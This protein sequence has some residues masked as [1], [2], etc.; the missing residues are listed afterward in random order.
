MKVRIKFS[1]QGAMKFIGHL[2]IMRYFQK[3]IRRAGI[4]IAYTEG[5]SPHM[6]MSFAN[7]LGVGLTSDGEYMD[8]EIRTPIS[9]KEALERLNAVMAEGLR[10]LSFRQVEDSK[11]SNAMALVAAAD[12]RVTFRESCMPEEGW[13]ERIGDFMNQ[14][15]I[16]IRKKTKSK[17]TEMEIRPHILE[18][19]PDGDGVFLRV[20]AGS[21]CNIRPEQV[22]EAF[23]GFA[24]FSYPDTGLLINRMELYAK[25]PSGE[26]FVSLEDLG[27][28]I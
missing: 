28:E 2:D 12:Y 22:M 15:S 25:R 11:A 6:I 7:P 1:K 8:I 16:V 3:A 23:A 26:G 18:M 10:V 20:S 13:Q 17:E 5:F 24:G 9:G 4:D 21:V 27:V 19:R 14:D